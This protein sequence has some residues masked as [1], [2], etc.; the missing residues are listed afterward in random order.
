MHWACSHMHLDLVLKRFRIS[1][2]Q[3][4]PLWCMDYFELKVK[5]PVPQEKLFPF[6]NY[7][8]GPKVGIFSRIWEILSEWPVCMA[9]QISKTSALPIALCMALLLFD[10]PGPYSISQLRMA[11]IPHFAFLSLN[12]SF[13]WGF[14][15]YEI[16][17]VFLLL[18]CLTLISLLQQAKNLKGQKENF[19]LTNNRM[20][21]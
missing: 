4:V 21:K 2:P 10:D 12:L 6:L 15:M 13:V 5:T 9:R 17:F 8:E 7:L 18:I 14:C 19:F 1:L 16:K 3:N 20:R 11:Y